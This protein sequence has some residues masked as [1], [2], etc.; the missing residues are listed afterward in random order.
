MNTNTCYVLLTANI[1]LNFDFV[2]A[3]ISEDIK[4]CIN[5]ACRA[6]IL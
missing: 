2:M 4:I 6:L 5:N 3:F 1:L